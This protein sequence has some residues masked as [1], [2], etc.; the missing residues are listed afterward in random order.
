MKSTIPMQETFP[1]KEKLVCWSAIWAGVLVAIVLGLLFELL[2]M[3]IGFSLFSPS[4]QV[5]YPLSIGTALWMILSGIIA[6]YFGGWVSGRFSPSVT[7]ESGALYG[8]MVSGISVLISIAIMASAVGTV[9]SGSFSA[10]SKVVTASSSAIQNGGSI[11]E[12]VIKGASKISPEL[13]DKV[14]NAIPDLKPIT[15][16]IYSKASS[17]VKENADVSPEK[18]KS[19]LKK[20]VFNYLDSIDEMNYDDARKDLVNMLVET[21]GK[22]PDEINQMVD[23]WKDSFDSAKEKMVETTVHTTKKVARWISQLALINFLVLLASV[24]A[25]AFGG[26]NGVRNRLY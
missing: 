26:I 8:L 3:A 25:A 6:L 10:L 23:D 1:V 14:K 13:T 22:T 9:L 16:K 24:I 11:A 15:D 4:N 5:L 12:K 20:L 19:Q 17:L 18:V 2:G 21:T 7:T